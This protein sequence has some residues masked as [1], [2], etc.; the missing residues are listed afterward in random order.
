VHVTPQPSAQAPQPFRVDVHPQRGVV[1]VVPVGELD[2]AS[3]GG[4]E[5]HLREL[6]D[7]GF[8]HIVLDLREL[9]FIDSTGIRLILAE[10]GFARSRGRDFSLID[11]PPAIA[12][13]LDICGVRTHVRFAPSQPRGVAPAPRTPAQAAHAAGDHREPTEAS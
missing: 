8:A 13:V 10:D 4:L 12:R 5:A 1:R 6:R 2:L 11:G 3:V 7:S 9:T